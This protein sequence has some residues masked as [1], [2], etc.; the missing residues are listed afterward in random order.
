L[1]S[2]RELVESR[3]ENWHRQAE[4]WTTLHREL[5]GRT[6]AKLTERERFAP[7]SSSPRSR[8]S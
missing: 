7:A 1:V 3:P 5:L 6:K 2:Y 4:K 8:G